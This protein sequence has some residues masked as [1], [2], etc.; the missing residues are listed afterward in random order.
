MRQSIEALVRHTATT[1]GGS[2]VT[3][4]VATESEVTAI[5]GAIAIVIGIIWSLIEKRKKGVK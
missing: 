4:G 3:A 1:I 2:L 5:A